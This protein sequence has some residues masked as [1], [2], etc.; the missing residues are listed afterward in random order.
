MNKIERDILIDKAY[1]CAAAAQEV[2]GEGDTAHWRAWHERRVA[3]QQDLVGFRPVY[4][5]REAA[6]EA[7]F[8]R[9]GL[10][11]AMLRGEIPRPPRPLGR[12]RLTNG[13]L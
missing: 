1:A 9:P 7:I 10:M 13:L 8:G 11:I 6:N 5:T 4:I 12:R 3:L 2:G